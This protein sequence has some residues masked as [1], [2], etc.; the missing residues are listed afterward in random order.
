MRRFLRAAAESGVPASKDGTTPEDRFRVGRYRAARNHEARRLKFRSVP[1]FR[2]AAEYSGAVFRT[3]WAFR[4]SGT[5]LP[6]R[7]IGGRRISV[8]I[9]L[10]PA[11]S[12]VQ[13]EE[14]P[15]HGI[16]AR[17][18]TVRADWLV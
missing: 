18:F 11:F 14:K 15:G 12:R 16:V 17:L 4:R 5:I 9:S 2:L 6:R 3:G 10:P 13:N 1:D 8:G 7:A